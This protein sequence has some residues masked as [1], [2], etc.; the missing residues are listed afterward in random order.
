VDIQRLPLS[1]SFDATINAGPDPYGTHLFIYSTSDD[2]TST[3]C[4]NGFQ[5]TNGGACLQGQSLGTG[6]V[7]GMALSYNYGLYPAEVQFDTYNYEGN[8]YLAVNGTTAF[9][10]Y[11]DQY[12][13]SFGT[14]A[15]AFQVGGEVEA[16]ST[17]D[18]PSESDSWYPGDGVGMGSGYC[19]ESDQA[20]Y[21]RA[22]YFYF[23]GGGGAIDWWIVALNPVDYAPAPT[24]TWEYY[25]DYNQSNGEPYWGTQ[26]VSPDGYYY[27]FFYF[28]GTGT[29]DCAGN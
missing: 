18:V 1:R 29:G 6:V 12:D 3:G 13:G 11:G 14:S 17:F 27:P 22:S 16:P 9:V 25:Y 15:G 2:Y 4:Y 19:A 8:W 26:D 24:S 28:G 20:G 21:H 10:Y 23:D 5:A 7:A